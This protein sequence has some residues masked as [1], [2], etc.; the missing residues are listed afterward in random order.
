M[1]VDQ[2]QDERKAE[3]AHDAGACRQ[4]SSRDV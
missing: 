4:G 2:K 1:L 3:N